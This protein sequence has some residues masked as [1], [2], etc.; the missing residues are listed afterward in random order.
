MQVQEFEGRLIPYLA[1]DLLE[2]PRRWPPR[3]V[4]VLER[5]Q[6]FGLIG[7]AEITARIRWLTYTDPENEPRDAPVQSRPLIAALFEVYLPRIISFAL[8]VCPVDGDNDPNERVLTHLVQEIYAATEGNWDEN[9]KTIATKEA[10]DWIM[11]K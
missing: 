7:L 4:E 8:D 9:T 3:E 11:G 5:L 6:R 2:E 1:S 10:N